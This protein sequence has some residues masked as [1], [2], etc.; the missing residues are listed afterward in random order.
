MEYKEIKTEN[1]PPAV[2]AYSQGKVTENLIFTSGQIG[3][4]PATKRPVRENIEAEA[5]RALQ[6]LIAVVEAGGGD[7]KS[8]IKTTVYLVDMDNYQLINRVYETFFGHSLPA[9]SVVEVNELPKDMNIEI[10]AIAV[11]N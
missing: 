4:D 11:K 7:K 8:I 5:R 10:E 9:R 2:G 3:L 1:A 6:N